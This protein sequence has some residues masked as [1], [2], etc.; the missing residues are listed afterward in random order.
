MDAFYDLDRELEQQAALERSMR[1]SVRWSI[2]KDWWEAQRRLQRAQKGSR[3]AAI[4][5]A[6]RDIKALQQWHGD[7]LGEALALQKRVDTYRRTI[8]NINKRRAFKPGEQEKLWLSTV[9][10]SE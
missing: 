6:I 4:T 7:T 8:R 1:R 9:I 3:G 5:E 10:N 2:L